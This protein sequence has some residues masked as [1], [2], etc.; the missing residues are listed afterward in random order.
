[1]SKFIGNTITLP[2]LATA[3]SS[4][5]N[6]DIYYNTTDHIVY[7]RVNGAWV[8]LGAGG[9]SGDITDVVAGAGLTGGATSGS[10]TLT[11][12]AG[13]GITV[14]PD[15]VAINTAT[16]PLKSDNLGVFGASTSAAIGVGSIELG[17]ASDTTITR[18]SAGTI[19][20][21]GVNVVTVS[22]AATLTNKTLTT[23]TISSILN[24][25]TLTLPTSTDTL[26]GRATTDTLTNKTLTAPRFAD[27]GFIA[28]AN[29][30][31]MVIF[32][33][34]A[35][36]SNEITIS[37]A[38]GANSPSISATGTA[39]NISLALTP[40][41]TGTV[42]ITTDLEIRSEGDIRLAD[43]DNSN[44]VGFKAPATVA[45]NISWTLPST[46]GGSGQVLGTNG[47]GVLSW[48]TAS[49]A[50]PSPTLTTSTRASSGTLVIGEAGQLVEMN[51]ASA[52]TL[53]VPLNSSVAFGIGTQI[54][55]L[56][57]GAGQTTIAAA[58]TV[59]INSSLGLKLRTQWSSATLIKRGTDTWALIGDTTI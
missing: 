33:N 39:T 56:Q 26:V 55:I 10:A 14:N 48:Y 43:S 31:E 19:A 44:W 23:P 7:S 27:L 16:V 22:G 29:G 17:H 41:G 8:D 40:K 28:D 49:T 57:I 32:D 5:T 25:G 35:S 36:A 58:G 38:S 18:S 37:N 1:M 34:V 4:P 51:N 46:D 42:Q 3:P 6:G 11:V 13:T 15:D 45:S 50:T 53:T 54:N 9:G 59:T 30:N 21:E 47:A 24:T 2:N 52:N 12:G 20:V